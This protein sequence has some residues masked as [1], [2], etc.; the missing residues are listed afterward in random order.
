MADGLLHQNFDL[1]G[2]AA[3]DPELAPEGLAG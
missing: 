1:G 3:L 2:V